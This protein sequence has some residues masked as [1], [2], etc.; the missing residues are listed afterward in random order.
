[1]ADIDT[2][3]NKN[4]TFGIMKTNCWL[5]LGTL[6]ATGAVAQVNT[7]AL[8]SVPPPLPAVTN[9]MASPAP[10]TRPAEKKTAQKKRHRPAEEKIKLI[11]PVVTLVPGL[12]EVC[13]SN[14]NVRG[15]AGLK[16]EVV[17]HVQKSDSVTVLS[18]I[19]LDKHK[20][21]EPAQWA[22]ILLPPSTKVWVDANFIDDA[23]KTVRP[24]KLN[25]RAGPSENYSVLGV[26]ERGTP[27][28]EI[29]TRNGWTQIETP[30]NAY[31]FV[32][33]MYLKQE[34]PAPPVSTVA[35]T[36]ETVPAT[37]PVVTETTTNLPEPAA[38]DTNTPAIAAS[39][40][41]TPVATATDTNA[42]MP[43]DVDT[44]L[45]PPPPRVVTHEGFVRHV[46]SIIEPTTYELFD[47]KTGTDIDYLYTT[48]T[49]LDI[50]RYNGLH[51]VVTG[52]EGLA[53]RWRNTPVLTIHEIQVVE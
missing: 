52:E 14:V 6:L 37:G 33:A 3:G 26:I 45:P 53:Q 11:E 24:K 28:S 4:F 1:M 19:T 9:T 5:V 20:S 35:T 12:A 36:T 27:I 25:L 30:T 16:G 32:A 41:N 46:T 38:V 18:E 23:N 21:G 51:I 43:S 40:T 42:V 13:E 2:D 49:N 29:V 50:S 15:Q 22:K 44:N 31:A 8:W 17:A 7:N 48:T 39:D 34:A 10:A 47:P